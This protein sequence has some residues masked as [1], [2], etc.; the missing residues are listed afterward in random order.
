M[1]SW[2]PESAQDV[3]WTERLSWR[4]ARLVPGLFPG[5]VLHRAALWMSAG[6]AHDVAQRL[7]EAAA[8]HYRDELHIEPLVRLR[9]HQRMFRALVSK[10]G[11]PDPALAIER[12]L[13]SL[14]RIESPKPPF[15]LV[16]ARSLVAT[17][18]SL[19]RLRTAGGALPRKPVPLRAA[20]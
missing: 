2:E 15:P 18:P 10:P 11:D 8:R 14:A 3:R 6:G 1:Q 17:W 12:G 20:A 5:A 13:L 19:I 9:I 7:F 16:D 4:L